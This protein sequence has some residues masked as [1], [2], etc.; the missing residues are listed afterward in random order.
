MSTKERLAKAITS[1][2]QI[3][4]FCKE[5]NIDTYTA[6][7]ATSCDSAFEDIT[8]SSLSFNSFCSCCEEMWQDTPDDSYGLTAIAEQVADFYNSQGRLPENV[9]ELLYGT[10]ADEDD[11]DKEE[12]D[13]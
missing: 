2:E 5:N 8:D 7:I 9:E 13:F 1:P 3:I 10:F 11:E 12:E 6:C 4:K